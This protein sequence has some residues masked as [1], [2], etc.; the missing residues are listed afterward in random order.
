MD[1]YRDSWHIVG[2]EKVI[3]EIVHLRFCFFHFSSP[4]RFP[5]TRRA[6]PSATDTMGHDTLCS[7]CTVVLHKLVHYICTYYSQFRP[8]PFFLVSHQQR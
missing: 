1:I 2:S 4:S 6:I 7:H 3:N 8:V 5:H